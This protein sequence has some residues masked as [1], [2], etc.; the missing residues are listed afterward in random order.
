MG[1]AAKDEPTA[2]LLLG[3]LDMLILRV[4]KRDPLHGW[5]I[6]DRIKQH[7]QQALS[8]GE[9]SLYPALYRLEARGWVTSEWGTSENNRRAKYYRLTAAGRKRL[10][11]E[12]ASWDRIAAA[13]AGVLRHA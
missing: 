3:T 12:Q 4:L 13:I 7:S 5:G 1:R 11:V 9:G 6:A 2:T 10:D 8:I